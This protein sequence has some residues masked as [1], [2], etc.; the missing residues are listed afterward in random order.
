MSQPV[1]RFTAGLYWWAMTIA[2]WGIALSNRRAPLVYTPPCRV[3]DRPTD[4]SFST[5]AIFLIVAAMQIKEIIVMVSTVDVRSRMMMRHTAQLR[6]LHLILPPIHAQAC[7]C[8][9]IQGYTSLSPPVPSHPNPSHLSLLVSSLS[10]R[11]PPM[12]FP[13]ILPLTF[14]SWGPLLFIQS[15]IHLYPPLIQMCF[16]CILHSV[17]CPQS[18]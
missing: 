2:W 12:T 10:F 18:L 7:P 11:S 14:F 15:S 4:R 9:K 5:G 13:V 17:F 3:P 1:G 16:V 8:S 6:R